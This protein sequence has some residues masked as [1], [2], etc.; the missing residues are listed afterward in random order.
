MRLLWILEESLAS[1]Q[2]G[3]IKTIGILEV[4]LMHFTV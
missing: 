3:A 1:E 4:S 2:F